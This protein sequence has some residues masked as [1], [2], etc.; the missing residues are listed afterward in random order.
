MEAGPRNTIAIIQNRHDRIFY[1]NQFLP[2][3][4]RHAASDAVFHLLR[5]DGEGH[6]HVPRPELERVITA[7]AAAPPLR[8]ALRDLGFRTGVPADDS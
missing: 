8:E 1:E 7:V 5:D 4:E 2:F 3:A 6:R